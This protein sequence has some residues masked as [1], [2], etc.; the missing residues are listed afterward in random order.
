[1]FADSHGK[2]Y[3]ALAPKFQAH[4]EALKTLSREALRTLGQTTSTAATE[5][6]PKAYLTRVHSTEE[7]VSDWMNEMSGQTASRLDAMSMMAS[8]MRDLGFAVM[9]GSVLVGVASVMI[10]RN[11]LGRLSRLTSSMFRLADGELSSAVPFRG[12][13]DEIG[14]MADALEVF[15]ALAKQVASKHEVLAAAFESMVEGVAIISSER[16]VL[17][18]NR[19]F[20]EMHAMA[21]GTCVGMQR[22]EFVDRLTHQA[23]W[24]EET[25]RAVDDHLSDSHPL[26]HPQAFDVDLSNGRAY[27]YTTALMPDGNLLM[28]IEDVTE[29]RVSAERIFHLA[30]HDALTDLPNRALFQEHLGAAVE[31][32]ICEQG[33]RAT[34]MLC[35]LDCFKQVNDTFGHPAGDELLRQVSRRMRQ[36]IRKTDV[37]ARLGGDEFAVLH[38]SEAG[39]DEAHALAGRLVNAIR[40]PFDIL[41]RAVAIGL[42][43]GIA[44]APTDAGSLGELMKR[45]DLA[46]YA[47]KRGGRNRFA[48][49]DADMAAELE[50]RHAL[51]TDMRKALSA[52]SFTLHYQPQVDLRTRRIIGCEALA[53]WTDP[54]RG[55]VPPGVFIPIA[56]ENGMIVE[57]G[58]W[59]L[60]KACLDAAAWDDD[61]TIAVN[62]SSQQLRE[63]GFVAMLHSALHDSGLKPER[64]E[65]EITETAMLND[66]E[67]VLEVLRTVHA[68]GIRLS[69][70]DF[71]T[72]Y[73]ALNYLQKFPFDKIKIDRS[74]VRDLG[75]RDESDAIVRA[76]AALGIN[77]GMAT[78]AEGIET[79]GQAQMVLNASCNLGQGYLF[80]R[81]VTAE[82]VAKVLA[83]Q[84]HFAAT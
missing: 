52:Q 22:Q 56:E 18:H 51:E 23:G 8:R 84:N 58:E 49:Y 7:D 31:D 60:R 14:R 21:S 47:A 53:R 70:D 5:F 73:S 80:G 66:T 32:A 26:D 9:L 45:A 11:L 79:E 55:D 68:L 15:R 50:E 20:A 67:K 38:L 39:P 57:L 12:A 59:V 83:E 46:L 3:A 71:G 35:D 17:L 65:L 13:Q 54:K 75:S 33:L 42:S 29:R 64:L 48:A 44:Q 16:G 81:A 34:L 36:V 77:L 6:Q 19:R 4:V 28:S 61:L 62:V 74:F 10:G 82:E 25:V 69:L 40:E 1:V 30:H 78:L 24:T 76:V 72:G 43:V 2:I 27:S 37:L 41:G 63:T